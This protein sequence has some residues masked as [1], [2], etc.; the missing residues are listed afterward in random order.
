MSSA[1]Y[2][3]TLAALLRH[4]DAALAVDNAAAHVGFQEA[5]LAPMPTVNASAYGQLQTLQAKLQIHAQAH[6]MSAAPSGEQQE[7]PK[8][9]CFSRSSPWLASRATA[10][11]AA[12]FT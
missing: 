6:A 7:Q 12:L 11:G 1:K 2:E 10:G 9:N 3:D 4:V 8:P 5:R